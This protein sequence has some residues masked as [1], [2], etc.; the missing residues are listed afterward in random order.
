MRWSSSVSISSSWSPLVRRIDPICTVGRITAPGFSTRTPRTRWRMPT[1]RSVPI[2]TEPSSPS[3]ISLTFWRIGLDSAGTTPLTMAKAVSSPSRLQ[4]ALMRFPQAQVGPTRR[5]RS[6]RGALGPADVPGLATGA[7]PGHRPI[8]HT[9][10]P[11]RASDSCLAVL[12]SRPPEASAACTDLD[13]G[14]PEPEALPVHRRGTSG[15][16]RGWSVGLAVSFEAARGT[17]TG[18]RAVSGRSRIS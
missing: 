18:K 15:A 11:G 7:S 2:R 14:P 9:T 16:T 5:P 8:G 3:A 1:S 13:R 17:R 4:K 10:A 6:D 12:A